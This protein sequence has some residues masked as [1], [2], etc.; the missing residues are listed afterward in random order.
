MYAVGFKS[1]QC[2]MMDDSLECPLLY[3]G[4]LLAVYDSWIWSINGCDG[5]YLPDAVKI[6]LIHG[7]V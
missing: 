5:I 7:S 1:R 6:L 2:I 4:T 3:D